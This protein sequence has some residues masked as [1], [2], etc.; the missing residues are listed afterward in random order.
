M[1]TEQLIDTGQVQ[2]NVATGP[3]SGPPLLL[4][5]GVTRRWQDFATLLPCLLPRWQVHAVDFRGHGRSARSP[6]SYLVVDYVKDVIWMLKNQIQGPAVL[7]G[8][9]L[10]A[11]VAGAVAAA[12]PDRVRAI[13]LED[14]PSVPLIQYIRQTPFFAL[15][16]GFRELAQGKHSVAETA[17][18]M[19]ELEIPTIDGKALVKMSVLRDPTHLRFGARCLQDM[20]PEVLAPLLEG[21]WLEGY[22]LDG[23]V[24]GIRCPVLLL[25][26]EE[27][28]GGMLPRPAAEYFA[29][30]VADCTLIDFPNVGHLIHWMQPEKAARH[31]TEFL[32]SLEG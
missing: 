20:D 18:R 28:L 7:L 27:A 2:L 24:A 14:P 8:H 13:V 26:G 12:V 1:L 10:G 16:Q 22:D 9:S 29:H 11:L 6:G 30:K 4:L 23:Y 32:E 15:F 3:K 31:V 5:H 21:R 17:R 25:R 19:A